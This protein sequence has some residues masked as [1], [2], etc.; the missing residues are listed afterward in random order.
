MKAA[1]MFLLAEAYQEMYLL[2]LPCNKQNSMDTPFNVG[3][4]PNVSTK[5]SPH[6][7][8]YFTHSHLPVVSNKLATWLVKV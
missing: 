3:R 2:H 6:G 4:P 7:T 1:G 8:A 5:Y